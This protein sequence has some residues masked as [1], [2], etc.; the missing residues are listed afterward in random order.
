MPP[1]RRCLRGEE[2]VQLERRVQ[3]AHGELL[4]GGAADQLAHDAA[5]ER[6]AFRCSE[7]RAVDRQHVLDRGIGLELA[8]DPFGIGAAV[9]ERNIRAHARIVQPGLGIAFTIRA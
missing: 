5:I 6:V 4:V 7:D 9:D 3:V 1:G 8:H 2:L